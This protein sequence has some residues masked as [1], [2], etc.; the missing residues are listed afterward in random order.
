MLLTS[1]PVKEIFCCPEESNFYSHSL[2]SLVL[3]NCTR[4]DVV[5]EF[6]SG[7]GSPVINSLI[8]TKFDGV[9]H[10][11]DLSKE[12]CQVA[13]S[14][15]KDSK[16]NNKYIIHNSSFFDASRPDAD[17]LISN[18]P[19]LPAWDNDLYQPLLHGGVDGNTISKQ[20]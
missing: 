9:I 4:S 10:G 20:R 8:R 12:A 15:I 5:V 16:L 6:G 1:K 19:Y 14:K 18:P 13:N 2:E 7:D 11:F 3:N 17:Y